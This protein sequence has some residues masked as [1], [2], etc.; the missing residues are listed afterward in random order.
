MDAYFNFNV[1]ILIIEQI[2]VASHLGHIILAEYFRTLNTT[3]EEQFRE[4]WEGE[5]D[6]IE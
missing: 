1:E 2:S 3:K 5:V 6:E 4:D